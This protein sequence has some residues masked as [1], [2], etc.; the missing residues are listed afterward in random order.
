MGA[1]AVL[2]VGFVHTSFIVM[3]ATRLQGA[4]MPLL[5]KGQTLHVTNPPRQHRIFILV[6]FGNF[7]QDA[8]A[9][10]DVGVVPRTETT[11]T[12]LCPMSVI[13]LHGS[14]KS[15][16]C[17]GFL[18]DS[19][20]GFRIRRVPNLFSCCVLTC[21][22]PALEASRFCFSES[23]ARSGFLPVGGRPAPAGNPSWI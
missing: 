13:R 11:T 8:C 3:Q 22:L 9:R 2:H 10:R 4:E 20:V 6:W 18:R 17:L 14:A 1:H 5:R 23:P 16:V 12:H 7:A 15:P 19:H 21:G